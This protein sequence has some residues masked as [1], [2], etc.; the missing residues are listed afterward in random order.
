MSD[1]VLV[2]VI[3]IRTTPEALWAALVDP[4]LN[5][6]YWWGTWQDCSWE[7][8][9]SW[10]WSFADGRV[11]DRGEVLE[12]DPPRRLVLSCRHALRAELHA[13][14]FSRAC[15]LLGP[16]EETVKLTAMHSMARPG[17][18]RVAGDIP[19]LADHPVEFDNVA[20]DRNRLQTN[21]YFARTV[22][23][24]NAPRRQKV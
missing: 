19:W 6:Q 14:G 12:I 18:Q 13:E 5:R 3:Y 11:A 15:F 16:V 8:G 17:A 7:Q 22:L 10:K 23:A 24:S 20:R 1:T 2:Y 9:A 4:V 21:A